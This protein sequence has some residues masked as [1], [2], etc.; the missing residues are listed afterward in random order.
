MIML[1]VNTTQGGG[2]FLWFGQGD[3]GR[4][5]RRRSRGQQPEKYLLFSYFILTAIYDLGRRAV[6]TTWEE[7]G[8]VNQGIGKGLARPLYGLNFVSCGHPVGKY[9][10]SAV[11]LASTSVRQLVVY[12]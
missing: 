11:P 8:H 10:G 2:S 3:A 7:S 5:T 1:G 6:G 12:L 9:L 4:E